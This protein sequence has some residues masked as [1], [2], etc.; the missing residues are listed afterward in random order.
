[1]R[2]SG[3]IDDDFFERTTIEA[4]TVY[5]ES[6]G[7]TFWASALDDETDRF[8]EFATVTLSDEPRTTIQGRVSETNDDEF[9][10]DTGLRAVRVEVDDL[11]YNP[12]DDEGYLKIA[13]GDYVRVF[14]QMDDDLFEGREFEADSVI[15]LYDSQ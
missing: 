3:R 1:M 7:T 13:K 10:I 12:L 9:V 2:V 4:R 15:K 5:V 8:Y 11:G 6:I 14:G